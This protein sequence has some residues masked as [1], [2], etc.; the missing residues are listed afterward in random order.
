M[1]GFPDIVAQA[2]LYGD[3]LGWD[4]AQLNI[5]SQDASSMRFE[6][7]GKAV[8]SDIDSHP[9]MLSY[10][11]DLRP[12]YEMVPMLKARAE[13]FTRWAE[14]DGDPSHVAIEARDVKGVF[15]WGYSEYRSLAIADG[16]GTLVAPKTPL[17]RDWAR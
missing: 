10:A 8:Y 3:A 15:P 13:W 11:L 7:R 9:K 4:A 5:T 6:L 12:L 16:L 17:V 2:I 14:E 1:R